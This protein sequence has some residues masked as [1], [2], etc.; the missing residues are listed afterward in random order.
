M[1]LGPF[2]RSDQAATR[3]LLDALRQASSE[4]AAGEAADLLND[5][6]APGSLWDAITLAASELLMRN[7]GI[8]ALH[9][10]TSSN[11]LHY[12]FNA[13]GDETN[14]KLA[15]LQAAGWIPLFRERAQTQNALSIDALEPIKPESEGPEAVAE[16]FDAVGKDR[17]IAARK[18]V[19]L[20]ERGGE[21]EDIFDGA[22]RMIFLKGRDSHQYKYG[23]AAWEESLLADDPRWRAPL[24]A[25][26][27]FYV[28]GSDAS[29][30]PLMIRAREAVEQVLG[31]RG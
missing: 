8:V 12:I 2:G 23:G 22:R 28:P 21:L 17:A 7:P 9:S 20:V 4:D 14:R 16:I 5:G 10:M 30:S 15:L 19:G 3:N 26:A 24:A 13:A 25:A 29:D 31:R 18:V 6:I 11:A 1:R 27:M